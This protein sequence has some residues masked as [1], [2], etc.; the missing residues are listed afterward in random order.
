MRSRLPANSPVSTLLRCG[1]SLLL[2][3]TFVPER[4]AQNDQGAASA[5]N[6]QSKNSQLVQSLISAR[7][8]VERQALLQS[9]APAALTVGLR[10]ALRTASEA[11]RL[12]KDYTGALAAD[13]SARLLAERLGDNEGVAVALFEMGHDRYLQGDS[14]DALALF[15]ESQK[16]DARAVRPSLLAEV[17]FSVG[18][19]HFER[20]DYDLAMQFYRETLDVFEKNGGTKEALGGTLYGIGA[21]YYLKGDFNTA[22]EYHERCLR[23]AQ[24]SGDQVSL[25]Y[26]YFGLA[27]DNRMKGDYVSA[28]EFYG[29]SLAGLEQLG[30][31]RGVFYERATTTILRHIGTTYFL[32]GNYRLALIYYE[33]CL[34]RDESGNYEAGI[35][36]SLMYIGGVYRSQGLYDRALE[37]LKKALASF[38]KQD[39][40]QEISHTLNIIGS[41]YQL[42]GD[43]TQ[44]QQYFERA[45]KLN[46]KI[47]ANEGIAA[48]LVNVASVSAALGDFKRSEA[49]AARAAELL[50]RNE[51]P[52]TL[53]SA[54]LM[55]G[56][57]KRALKDVAGA[58]IALGEAIKVIESMR[59][60]VAGGEEN[61]ELFFADK[62]A[63][64][65]EMVNLLAAAGNADEAFAYAE[66]AKAR[67]LVDV[68]RNG[69]HNP[70]G[71]MTAAEKTHDGEL[72]NTLATINSEIAIEQSHAP[73]DNKHLANLQLRLENART[74]YSVF[75]MA[76]YAAHPELRLECG[77][78]PTLTPADV[79]S[80]VADDKTAIVE[81][82]VTD[83]RTQL[84]VFTRTGAQSASRVLLKTFSINIKRAELAALIGRFRSQLAR[85]D[86]LF[87]ANARALYD[88]L[89][90]PAEEQLHGRTRLVL[91]PDDK[92]WELPFQALQSS[93]GRY[94]IEQNAISYAPS[95]T[96]LREMQSA[97][98]L[99]LRTKGSQTL[100]A[101]GNPTLAS[102]P[103]ARENSASLPDD[104]NRISKLPLLPEAERQVEA[105]GQLYGARLSKIYTGA[106]ASEERLKREAAS[107]S[108]L[109]LASH[110]VLDDANPM[111]SYVMLAQDRANQSPSIKGGARH[112]DGMLQ[113]WELMEMRLSAD[114]VI[115]SACET[116]RGE[117]KSGEG[118]IG[119]SWALLVAGCPTSVVSQWKVESAST[120]ELMLNFHRE[121]HASNMRAHVSGTGNANI[122]KAEALRQAALRVLH[123]ERYA[124]P[125]Y[126]AGFVMIG[127]GE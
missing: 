53:W 105:L 122:S 34:Q 1:L 88:L 52:Q 72:K 95:L 111:Y 97:R 42:Q 19:F 18:A 99:H 58:R 116:A 102:P 45:L 43:V 48:T 106:A 24:E 127:D 89:L 76:L 22:L 86:L 12:R 33:R 9:V 113:A 74:E 65:Y 123:S 5:S 101:F 39:Y 38:E 93:D 110:G 54:L 59:Q 7:T 6:Q 112:E 36:N 83:E 13:T 109:H 80:L 62:V 2:L 16:I 3:L 37:S 25:A 21:I 26:A 104:N 30:N 82:V 28:L 85:R 119:L 10:Q 23:L 77:E 78:V 47:E 64:Y 55:L 120:T 79:G 108:I 8:D 115:L 100:L 11:A 114:L 57:A 51:N 73:P 32:Q 31:K 56:K 27:A 84:F 46:E 41:V 4:Q 71:S 125:F 17:L 15:R 66:R 96:V 63:P 44:A 124:H 68:L 98:R 20:G 69:R 107:Y 92:L 121:L 35:A 87:T 70:D 50:R 94:L 81:Y 103:I 40:K 29:K 60:R 126:W 14:S 49:S 67:V 61:Q 117:I 75:Q 91:V 118:V 90:R